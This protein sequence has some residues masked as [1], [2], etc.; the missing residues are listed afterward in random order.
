MIIYLRAGAMKIREKQKQENRKKI[1][2]SA[3]E[4]I[5]KKGIKGVSMREIA[6]KAGLGDAAIYNYFPTREAIVYAYYED[7]LAQSVERLRAISGFNE[8][9]LQEQLQAFFETQLE[10][11]LPDR[12][13]VDVTFWA[14]TVSLNH[15]DP[16]LKPIRS[17]FLCII[18]DLFE[19]AVEVDE[20]PDQVFPEHTYNLF[21]DYNVGLVFYWL[22]DRSNQFQNTT[23][24]LDKSLDLA[25][26]IFKAGIVNKVL[27]I[28]TFLFKN[29]IINQLDMINDPM[30]IIHKVKRQF[31]GG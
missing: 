12:E 24:L 17:R 10:V 14:V 1:I 13:F 16:Y 29:H 21:W 18:A 23:I 28:A 3:V 4:T 20:I 5:T 7:Q 31:M 22:K 11:F 8:F 2:R 26:S 25:V 9:S 27:D 15:D 19:A 6:R 30:E